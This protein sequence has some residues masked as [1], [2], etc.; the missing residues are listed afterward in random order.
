MYWEKKPSH[1]W[2][3]HPTIEHPGLP[4]LAYLPSL[5]GIA[6]IPAQTVMFEACHGELTPVMDILVQCTCLKVPLICATLL[7]HSTF[8]LV[9]GSRIHAVLGLGS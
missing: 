9:Q 4:T 2:E 7:W 8:A 1:M 3:E 6:P 5:L